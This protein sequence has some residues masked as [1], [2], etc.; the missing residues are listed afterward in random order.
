MDSTTSAPDK[1]FGLKEYN[2]LFRAAMNYVTRGGA[3]FLD[4]DS[5]TIDDDITIKL[6]IVSSANK[7][8]SRRRR[9]WRRQKAT[10]TFAIMIQERGRV[11]FD[12]SSQWPK[13]CQ[14]KRRGWLRTF[15][16]GRWILRLRR[17]EYSQNYWRV[18]FAEIFRKALGL[19]SEQTEATAPLPSEMKYF[20]TEVVHRV[21]ASAQIE[22]RGYGLRGSAQEENV[23]YKSVK[24]LYQ[25]NEVF[26]ASYAYDPSASE[27]PDRPKLTVQFVGGDWE[28]TLKDLV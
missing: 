22:V 7:P 21:F 23:R 18:V 25:G 11:V 20:P 10:W 4:D 2:E 1:D 16:K 27:L 5:K 12:A 17:A 6:Q 26:E 13:N 19:L 3:V 28:K 24:V 9:W 15:H 8:A 14:G